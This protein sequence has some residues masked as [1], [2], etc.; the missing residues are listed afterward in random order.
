MFVPG[1]D[2]SRHT[3]NANASEDFPDC[4]GTLMRMSL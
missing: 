4:R 3:I 1:A 2:S